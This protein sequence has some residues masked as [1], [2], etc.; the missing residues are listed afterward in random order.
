MTAER[1]QGLERILSRAA[2]L[3]GMAVLAGVAVASN[4]LPPPSW[5]LGILGGLLLAKLVV[6][7]L[8]IRARWAAWPAVAMELLALSGVGA[9]VVMGKRL[10]LGETSAFLYVAPVGALLIG[11]TLIRRRAA[12]SEGESAEDALA[13]E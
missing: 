2:M 1:V 7:T 8:G 9:L 4:R 5:A 11:A 6:L 3:I 10:D 12:L 13:D